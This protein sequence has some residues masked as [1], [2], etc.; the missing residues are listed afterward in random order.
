MGLTN[1]NDNRPILIT[2][3]TGT[4]KTAK[5]K[6]LLPNAVVVYANEMNIQDLGSIPRDNG[7]IIEDVNYKP[8][9]DSILNVIRRYRGAI[10]LTS[11][12]EKNVP[13]TIKNM[14]QI[15]RAGS[16]N[17]MLDSIKELAPHSEEPFSLEKDTYSLVSF[18][19]KET[20]R[21]LVSEVLKFNKPSDT[22]VLSWIVEN[23]HPNKILFIDGVVKRRWSQN[24]FYEMLAY[25]HGGNVRG[26][27]NMP[28]RGTYSK[29]PRLLKRIGIRNADTRI[30]NQMKQ[31]DEFVKYAKSKFNNGDCRILSLGEKKRRRKTEPVKVQ[32]NSL[33]DY[34][35][36]N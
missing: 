35:N 4:G 5:A 13:K 25:S 11:I 6:Q 17:H 12:N 33:E 30:F 3:K 21:D 2:G 9:T 34:Y 23:I 19:L 32:Q 20:D 27:I 10:V 18:F 14:C 15:K 7:I 1:L 16:K 29:V 22:Q 28:Y 26:R 24:Y 8:K 36:G 31:D